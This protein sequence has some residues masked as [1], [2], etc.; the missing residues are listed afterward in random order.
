M[1]NL[2][3]KFLRLLKQTNYAYKRY[4]YYKINWNSRLIIIK[5][6]RGVGKTTI[7][8]QYIKDKIETLSKTLYISL[9]D[10][11]F[12][13]N[14]LSEFVEQFVM[15]GGKNLFIDEVHRY[16]N[17][18][19]EIKNIYD[20]YPDLK[21]VATGSSA[22]AIEK[23]KADL[24][25]RASVYHLHTLSL[26]EFIAL[27]HKIEIDKLSIEEIVDS[28]EEISLNINKFIKP[29]ELFN[30]FIKYG[31]YPFANFND[32]LFY[33][34]LNS[35]VNI[36]IDNDI[37]T[38]ENI[39]YETRIKVKKLLYLI[40]SAV[41]FK[42]NVA[43][44][45]KKVGTSRDILLKYLHL[46]SN[47]EIINLLNQSGSPTS[48]LQKPEKIYINNPTLMLALDESA[49]VGTLRE[50][51]FMNQVSSNHKL[52]APKTG[53]FLV[54]NKYLFEIGGKNKTKKQIAGIPNS[55]TVHADM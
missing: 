46:I 29:V 16:P 41:P 21:V 25:R 10:I 7:M 50:T 18:S 39:N 19:V 30:Q 40:S 11:Y 54:D 24:S 3:N 6:Q 1:E 8:L 55:F 45:S 53:D 31:S 22:I 28:H 34:K 36:T 51:F 35:I 27:F 4:L 47:A 20:F 33:D 23:A 44:L 48:I 9:D 37:P 5:G 42:P 15:N 43:E 52:N 12:S 2:R 17:W 14:S 26:R 38:F 32:P 13:G 49:N